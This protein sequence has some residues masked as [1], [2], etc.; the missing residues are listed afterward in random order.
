[1]FRH[2][3]H[4]KGAPTC[5]RPALLNSHSST[6]RLLT[7]FERHCQ[8]S[9]SHMD[10]LLSSISKRTR[11]A[12]LLRQLPLADSKPAHSDVAALRASVL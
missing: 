12:A 4:V 1:M 8:L 9:L 3:S 6:P 5:S 2:R 7:V 11:P 10:L